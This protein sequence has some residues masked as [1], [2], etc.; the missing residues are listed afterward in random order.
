MS[1]PPSPEKPL[2][3]VQRQAAMSGPEMHDPGNGIFFAAVKTTRMPMIVTDPNLPDNPII[4]ANPAF[5]NMTG[6]DAEEILGRNCRFLQ[7]A[8]TDQETVA[9][10]GRA[11]REQRET[12]VEIINYKK[13][14]SAFWNALFISPVFDADD[15]LRYHFASQLD[16]T[17][18][19]DAEEALRQAQ[20]M[21]A[22]GQLTG[23][24]A[25]D[26]NNLLTVIQGFTDVLLHQ[27][28]RSQERPLPTDRARRS[29][30]AVMEAADRG[31]ELTQQLL[32]F[33]R[34][35][36]LSGRV[37]NVDEL[38]RTLLPMLKRTI[39][40]AGITIDVKPCGEQCNARIDPVQAEAAVIGI[41]MN[42]RDAMPDGGTIMISAEHVTLDGSDPRYGDKLRGEFVALSIADTGTGMSEEV[43]ARVTEPFFTTKDQGK[44]TGLGLSMVYG[45]MKQSDGALHIKSQEGRGTTVCLLFPAA[46]SVAEPIRQHR[47]R[48]DSDLRGDE[49]VLIV[50]DQRDVGDLAEA[51]LRDFGYAAL[52]AGNGP[53]AI[54]ILESDA[55][56]DLLFTDLIMPGGM[57]GVMVAREARR[58]RPRLKVLLTTGYAEASIER[59]DARGTEFDLIGKPY[60]RVDLAMR[61]RQVLDGATGTG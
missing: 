40:S 46:R 22:V 61:V 2:D 11:I 4:F 38:V 56:I 34:R 1:S 48:S 6:Y 50:E 3:I 14:G 55:A 35:Q 43:R 16:V 47:T 5:L 27:I 44:G 8:D 15:T 31:A 19:R 30:R 37:T 10:I 39:G 33:S 58:M 54:A 59:V 13:N 18:R 52:R 45:F 60:K 21:E 17:R 32:A 49:T 23:G 36:K 42:A 51:I 41:V 29:L 25:H 57:N 53:E 26:F 28:D 9:E 12:S 20:K 24:I 7:G